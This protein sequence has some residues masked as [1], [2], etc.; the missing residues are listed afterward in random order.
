MCRAQAEMNRQTVSIGSNKLLRVL[1][2]TDDDSSGKEN[3]SAK[4]GCPKQIVVDSSDGEFDKSK[5]P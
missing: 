4:G 1:E 3:L 2:L 5:T